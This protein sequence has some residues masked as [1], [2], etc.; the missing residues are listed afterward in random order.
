MIMT[1][2]LQQQALQSEHEMSVVGTFLIGIVMVSTISSIAASMAE[3]YST[4][5]TDIGVSRAQCK[6]SRSDR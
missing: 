1:S 4:L 3:Y 6:N 5:H 2:S